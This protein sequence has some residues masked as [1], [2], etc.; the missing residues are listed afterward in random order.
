[1][2]YTSYVALR[3]DGE[4]SNK[5]FEAF[6]QNE[7][8]ARAGVH[9]IDLLALALE[10]TTVAR[11]DNVANVRSNWNGIAINLSL[12]GHRQQRVLLLDEAVVRN[13]ARGKCRERQE[14]EG[15]WRSNGRE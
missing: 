13:A 1:M 5:K 11:E 6:R 4:T 7:G 9:L 2:L 14:E 12:E 10:S 3:F 8:W 15:R